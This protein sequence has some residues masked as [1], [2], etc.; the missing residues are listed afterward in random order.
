MKL[1]ELKN[2][3]NELNGVWDCGKF[4]IL[5]SEEIEGCGFEC[6]EEIGDI[7]IG[8]DYFSEE[9]NDD[10]KNKLQTWLYDDVNGGH[11]KLKSFLMKHGYESVDVNDGS[12]GGLYYG[13]ELFRKV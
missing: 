6:S 9:L 12:G 1:T 2:V 11:M 8:Y 3:L 13:A 7:G 4:E 5:D 10:D